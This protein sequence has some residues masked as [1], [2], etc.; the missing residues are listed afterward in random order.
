MPQYANAMDKRLEGNQYICGNK[1]TI[2]DFSLYAFV[3]STFD[4]EHN[5]AYFTLN[6][7]LSKYP[8]LQAHTQLMKSEFKEYM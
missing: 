3:S 2:A 4:N 7:I 6:F 5:E 1:I 8:N